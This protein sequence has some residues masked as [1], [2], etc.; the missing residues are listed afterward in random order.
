MSPST[1]GTVWAALGAVASLV[2][3]GP[4]LR[5]AIAHRE[6]DNGLSFGVLAIGVA[7]WGG[8]AAFRPFSPE[9]MTQAYFYLLSLV[10]ASV[11]GLGWFLFASTAHSTP[12]TLSHP[13]VYAGVA[14]VVG[15]NVGLVVTTPIHGVYWDGIAE[16]ATAF[17]TNAVVPTTAYWAHTLLVAGLFA[18]GVWLFARSRGSRRDRR[19]ARAYAGCAAAV[20]LGV[21]GSNVAVPGSGAAT[22]VVASGLL[23]VGVVQ[24]RS[25]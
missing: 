2:A 9:P 11:A 6:S 7:I 14:L 21:V 3:V 17:G 24:A 4:G 12:A 22:P 25:S 20:A 5:T 18:A 13:A 1:V 15:A 8:T 10:G 23:V 19:F 16:T